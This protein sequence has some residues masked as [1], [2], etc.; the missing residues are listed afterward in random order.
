MYDSS[1]IGNRFDPVRTAI[2]T[3]EETDAAFRAD[4]I[5]GER[6]FRRVGAVLSSA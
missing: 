4:P 6:G 5:H 1:P 3:N 2:V